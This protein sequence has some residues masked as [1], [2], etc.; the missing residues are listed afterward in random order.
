MCSSV[1]FVVRCPGTFLPSRCHKQRWVCVECSIH[2]WVY[3]VQWCS[4]AELLA[5]ERV[6]RVISSRTCLSSHCRGKFF[7]SL[8]LSSGKSYIVV[9]FVAAVTRLPSIYLKST[10]STDST[11]FRVDAGTCVCVCVLLGSRSTIR[12]D[13][14]MWEWDHYRGNVFTEPLPQER[15]NQAV[16]T[17]SESH[18]SNARYFS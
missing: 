6:C 10:A 2:V 9:K 4:E 16:Q 1:L 14:N 8:F 12:G 17:L 3:V 18:P 5:R 11:I 7:V 15:V 13:E